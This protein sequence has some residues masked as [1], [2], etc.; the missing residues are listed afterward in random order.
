MG[1]SKVKVAVRIRPMNR[2]DLTVR[3][4][5]IQ[6]GQ[7]PLSSGFKKLSWTSGPEEVKRD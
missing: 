2:R 3:S 5:L 6:Y 1:D 7:I 4:Q